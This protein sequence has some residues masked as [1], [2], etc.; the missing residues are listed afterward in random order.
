MIAPLTNGS[1]TQKVADFIGY[2][3]GTKTSPT[4]TRRTW[5]ASRA[6]FPICAMKVKRSIDGGLLSPYTPPES[7]HCA[8]EAAITKTTPSGCTACTGTGTSTCTGGLS[9]RHGFCE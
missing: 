5:R 6:R 8:F 4:S 2:I 1:P 9:C 3:N 7:C